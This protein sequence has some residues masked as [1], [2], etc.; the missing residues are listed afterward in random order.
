MTGRTGIQAVA[1]RAI[2]TEQPVRTVSAVV[3]PV[4]RVGMTGRTGT[5]LMAGRATVRPGQP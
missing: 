3:V 4:G 1:R 5:R 2:V